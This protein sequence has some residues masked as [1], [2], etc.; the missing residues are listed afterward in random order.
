M[1]QSRPNPMVG[2]II[3]TDQ[4]P[5]QLSA[6]VP[7]VLDGDWDLAGSRVIVPP[8][9]PAEGVARL[10][11]VGVGRNGD[12]IADRAHSY[13]VH[14]GRVPVA[15]V[16]RHLTWAKFRKA[17]LTYAEPE[18]E[19]YAPLTH[20]DL[21]DI[22]FST[23]PERAALIR[24]N[25]WR[26]N[27]Y[28]LDIGAHWGYMSEEL[29]RAGHRCV[30]VE[31]DSI[32]YSFMRRLRRSQQFSYRTVL[33]DIED[34]LNAEQT[35]DVVLALAVFHH[36]IKTKRGHSKLIR[37]LNKLRAKQIFLWTHNP[38]EEQMQNAYKNYPPRQFARLVME[39]ARL[40]KVELLGTIGGRS[41]FALS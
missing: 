3:W 11:P 7:F 40:S 15:V 25:V 24:K 32:D 36:F 37:T 6:S 20:I 35:F 2:D 29:E 9:P 33:A 4:F 38:R 39:H 14:N 27:A 10:L 31:K 18:G 8:P 34:F 28:I 1:Y 22:P 21:F 5:F 12:L 23:R 30:A 26:T 19:V 41:L 13:T 16:G 17:I